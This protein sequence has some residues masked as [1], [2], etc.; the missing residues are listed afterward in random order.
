[1]L[2]DG[3]TYFYDVGE[4]VYVL[5]KCVSGFRISSVTLYQVALLRLDAVIRKD[6]SF[7][8]HSIRT[9]I[10]ARRESR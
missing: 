6:G 7:V 4:V 1:M 3:G 9:L 5:L 8:A 2:T 10:E